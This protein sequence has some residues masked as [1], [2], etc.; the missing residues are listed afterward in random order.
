MPATLSSKDVSRPPDP[1]EGVATQ[2]RNR[3][4]LGNTSVS[5]GPRR[6]SAGFMAHFSEVAAIEALL[7][8]AGLGVC[9]VWAWHDGGFAPEQWLPGGLL[10][11]A[12]VCTA[13]ASADVRARLRTRPLPLVLFGLYVAWSY[14]SITW[15]QVPADALDGANR[16]LVYWLVFA[17]FWGLGCSER[18]STLGILAWGCA[19]AVLGVVSVAQAAAAAT[20]AGHFVQGRLAAPIS[21]PDGDAALFLSACLPLLVLASR[22]QGHPAARVAAGAA[23]AVLIDL[24]VLC[25]SRG[26][27]VALPCSLL[28]YLAVARNRLRALLPVL[29]T[30]AAVAPAV[31]ALLHVYTAV[32]NT[33]GRPVA[34]TSAATWIGG[35]AALATTGFAVLTLVDLR[36]RVPP[37]ASR[38]AGRTLGV[39]A[40]AAVVAAAVVGSMF[41]PVARAEHAW[42]DFTTNRKAAPTT[43]HFASGLGTSRYDVWRIAVRQFEA[44]PLTGVGADNF[45]VGY[46]RQRR[47][48]EFSRYPESVELRTFSETGIVGAA[49]F[50]GFLTLA[51]LRAARAARRAVPPGVA[52]ACVAGAGY[53]VF[54]ASVDW[55]WELPALTGAALALLGIAAAPAPSE[56]PTPLAVRRS[57]IRVSAIAAAACALLAAAALAVPWASVSL[58]DAAMA[59]G[60]GARAYSLLH[61]AAALNPFSEQPALAEATLAGNVRDRRRERAALL[62]A[63]RRNPHDWYVYFMLGIIAGREHKLALARAEL[64]DAHRLSPQ[65]LFVVY[66]QRRLQEGEPLTESR[67]RQIFREETS[68]L[69]GVRQR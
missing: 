37:R 34:V 64:A 44:H 10:L 29:V 43:L 20:A 4:G 66:A 55:F 51:F 9:V 60:A 67:V 68:T 15:A 50:L 3:E 16:T 62:Q 49:L 14:L 18:V 7:A 31:P 11:L 22:R 38:L 54:H 53:W 63:R 52:L 46:L 56:L 45:A 36:F 59:R 25:Q 5:G 6:R 33:R 69:R 23:A 57:R 39:S 19:I 47:T 28:L 24:A 2:P 42:H 48:G 12:L 32:V 40:A 27:L 58:I 13:S 1:I 41:N 61:E 30:G 17:L 26:S 21:Y 35:S 65:D 8:L